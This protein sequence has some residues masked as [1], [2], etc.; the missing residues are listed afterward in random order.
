MQVMRTLSIAA[1]LMAIAIAPIAD[2]ALIA[3][4][5]FL[6][7]T[8]RGAGEYSPGSDIRGQGAAAFGWQGGPPDG[9]GVPHAGSTSNFQ[10]DAL[11]EDSPAVGYEAGGRLR[12]L[13]VGNSSF[14][15]NIT[16]QLNPTPS[17]SEWWFSIQTNRLGWA[18]DQTNATYAVGGFTDGS[19]NGLQVGYD[20]SGGAIDGIPDLV[21]RSNGVNTVL[22]SDVPSSDNQ[23]VIV[24]LDVNTSGD[25]TISVWADPSTVSPLG[26]ADVTITDQNLTDSLTPF[27]QSKYESPGQSG[28][29][30]WDEIRLAT[31]FNSVIGIPEPTTAMLCGL[32]VCLLGSRRRLR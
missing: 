4:D 25:D 17:S 30:F 5:P 14:D 27:T 8:N 20:N 23:L 7:G 13:G 26:P 29:V 18:G 24:K 9:F 12:W 1:G 32:A 2:A 11:G 15:R 22:V 10:P 3:N 31:D 19:G 21:L 16:R 6:S 28:T